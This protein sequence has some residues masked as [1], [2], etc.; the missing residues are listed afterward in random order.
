M[1]LY[2]SDTLKPR[3]VCA[4]ARYLNSPVEFIYVDL[5][6]G[7]HKSPQFLAINPN[8]KVPALA[9]G[10]TKLWE[11]NAIICHLARIAKSDFWPGDQR[12]TEVIRWLSWNADH[13]TRH[14]SALY[15]E[16]MI[17]ARFGIGAPD[18]AAVEEATT[19]FR[20]YGRVLNDHLR[21]RKYLVGDS[22]TVADFDVAAALPYAS[23]S[24]MPIAE[25][26]EI[27][28]WNDRLNE[29]P[30][31]RNPYPVQHAKVA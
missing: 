18:E 23:Q 11:A 13:F 10:D 9:D 20:Q 1:K 17:K 26:P 16:F 7:E 15:F 29:L 25:F 21:N 30:A 4:A 22:L 8:G 19:Y 24:R 27:E 12:Q 2:Y 28:R 14:A 5:H 3:K 6:K 31:W